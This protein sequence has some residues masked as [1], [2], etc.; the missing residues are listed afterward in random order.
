MSGRAD[1]EVVL[2][3]FNGEPDHVHGQKKSRRIVLGQVP[4]GTRKSPGRPAS[5][6]LNF[7]RRREP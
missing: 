2:K 7:R 3:E 1:F 5:S 6:T 4:L